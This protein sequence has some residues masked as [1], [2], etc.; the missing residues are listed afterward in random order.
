MVRRTPLIAVN[1]EYNIIKRC[2]V[3]IRTVQYFLRTNLH[4]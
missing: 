4:R 2:V 1:V 3:I